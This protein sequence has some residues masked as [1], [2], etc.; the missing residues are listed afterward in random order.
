MTPFRTS[1]S[2]LLALGLAACA[3]DNY[4]LG[5]GAAFLRASGSVALQN[6]GGTLVLH[7]E[8]NDLRGS[9]DVGDTEPSPYL[10]FETNLGPQHIRI[11][12][13]GYDSNGSGVLA[14]TFGDIPAGTAVTTSMEFF[15]A[16][17][18][19][20]WDLFPGDTVRL[21]PGV[22][23]AFASL[24][25]SATATTPSVFEKVDTDVI[26]PMPY[27][28]GAVAL[29]PVTL[30][31][32][33]GVMAAKLGDANGRYWDAEAL[34]RFQPGDDFELFAGWRYLLLDSHGLAS[35][36]DFDADIYLNGWFIGGG[37]RF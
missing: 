17:A 31:A 12:G 36:R 14:E 6:D 4:R 29:G 23:A 30:V 26:V 18:A 27:L 13:F 3:P 5:G 19:W 8:H 15:S 33:A 10:R 22:Q 1:S 25:V 32:D 2:L 20:S 24:D 9:L 35:D 16:S 37:V 34:L 11:H 21:A 28:E 7:D